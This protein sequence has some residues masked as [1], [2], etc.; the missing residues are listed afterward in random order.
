MN[1]EK[2]YLHTRHILGFIGR[3]LGKVWSLTMIFSGLFSI[4]TL[5]PVDQRTDV[6]MFP[7]AKN[8]KT[9]MF[10]QNG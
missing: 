7:Y 4:T 10:G 3:E 5:T 8:E 2:R 1:R 9:H 6:Q